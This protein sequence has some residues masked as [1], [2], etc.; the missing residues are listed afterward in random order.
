[1][2]F[3]KIQPL[4]AKGRLMVIESSMRAYCMALCAALL[5]GVSGTASAQSYPSQPIHFLVPYPAGFAVDTLAREIGQKLSEKWGQPVI[6]DNRSGAGGLLGIERAAKSLPDGYTVLIVSSSG[7]TVS[8]SMYG[9]V[10][11]DPEKD[12]SPVT[13]AA[14][15]SQVLVVNPSVP[16]KSVKELIELAK[17]KP[18]ELNYA[19]T[20]N[21]TMVHLAGALFNKMAGVDMAHIP[22]RG[23]EAR[24][25]L[26]AGR[27][28]VMFAT[29]SSVLSNVKAGN[30]RALAVTGSARSSV[31]PDLPTISEAGLPGYAAEGWI[32]ALVPAGTPNEII[33]K[34]NNEIVNILQMPEV[35]ARLVNQGLEPVTNTPE[36][37]TIYLKQEIAKWAEAVKISG[38]RID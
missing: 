29:V 6:I 5:S 7:L 2:D 35:R 31:M 3:L 33:T 4:I 10:P 13:L 8:P 9:N 15:L 28:S 22:Y 11:Y 30:L 38:A 26:L 32:G 21:G 16:A 25:D 24:V 34:L 19:S 20:G 37:F 36:Q 18:G 12:F 27:V 14:R 17:S 1:M 23:Q